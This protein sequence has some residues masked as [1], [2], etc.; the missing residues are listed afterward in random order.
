MLKVFIDHIEDALQGYKYSEILYQYKRGLLDEMNDRACDVKNAGLSDDGVIADLIRSEYPDIRGSYERYYKAEKKRRR[1]AI[2]HKL[3]IIGTP[4]MILL[5]IALF[6]VLGVLTDAWSPLWLLI[7][8]TT[9]IMLILDM[10]A[11]IRKILRLKRIFHPLARLLTAGSIMLVAVFVY[12]F[13]GAN[14]SAWVSAWPIVPAGVIALLLGDLIFAFATHQKFSMI[15]V[16]IYIP[17]ICAMLYVIL[18]KYNILVTW[19][20]GWVLVFLGIIIDACIGLAILL[21][22]ARFR[23]KQEVEDI[24]NEN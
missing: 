21:D 16:F 3:L 2:E 11:G 15:N 13:C 23:Y 18:A 24:W 14:F 1:E 7:V 10:L 8:G 5:S 4:V 22:N 6:V 9:F 12:L 20:N 19:Q 17:A